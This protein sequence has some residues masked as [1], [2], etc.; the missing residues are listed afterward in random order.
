MHIWSLRVFRALRVA[1]GAA[2]RRIPTHVLVG[3]EWVGDGGQ[4][5][6]RRTLWHLVNKVRG[7]VQ[8]EVRGM[9]L[10]SWSPRDG[11]GRWQRLWPG[12]GS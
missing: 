10:R 7:K 3:M 1:S 2:D 4:V 11:W 9:L 5:P 6:D 8:Y 12:P